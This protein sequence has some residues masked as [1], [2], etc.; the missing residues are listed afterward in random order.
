MYMYTLWLLVVHVG[1]CGGGGGG[2]GE[3]GGGGS[4]YM[5]VYCIYT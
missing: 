2:G 3:G 1:V 5:S 4:T